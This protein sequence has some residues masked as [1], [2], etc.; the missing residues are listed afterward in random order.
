MAIVTI[1]DEERAAMRDWIRA[2]PEPELMWRRFLAQDAQIAATLERESRQVQVA[3]IERQLSDSVDD[4][5]GQVL[6]RLGLA[7]RG[8]GLRRWRYRERPWESAARFPFAAA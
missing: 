1:T 7:G 5:A 3:I 6:A 2:L 4:L 8:E